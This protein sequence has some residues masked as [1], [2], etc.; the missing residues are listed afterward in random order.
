M[1]LSPEERWRRDLDR[2]WR[3]FCNQLV[4]MATSCRE[5]GADIAAAAGL[6]RIA[7]DGWPAATAGAGEPGRGSGADALPY[8][9]RTGNTVAHEPEIVTVHRMLR[10]NLAAAFHALEA[11]DRNVVRGKRLLTPPA[12][13]G[14]ARAPECVN[15]ARWEIYSAAVKAGR[16]TECFDYRERYHRDAPEKVVMARPG[17]STPRQL[18][19]GASIPPESAAWI[20]GNLSAA[21]NQP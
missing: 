8:G 18:A 21:R 2:D 1:P 4:T 5:L 20:A 3:A 13:A 10:E 7:A 16:C 15:C 19:R 6:E 17:N 11:A 14:K 12:A 9:D